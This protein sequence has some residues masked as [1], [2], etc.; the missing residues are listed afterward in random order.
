MSL[1]RFVYPAACLALLA[2]I[3][4]FAFQ[5]SVATA[6][7]MT[8][9][10][11]TWL[12]TLGPEQQKSALF[13]Y[14]APERLGWHFIP[15]ET[16]KG[17]ALRDMNADQKEAATRLL[18]S[19]LSNVGYRKARQVMSLEAL[20]RIL[21]DESGGQGPERD[22]AKYYFTI[23][24]KP[25]ADSRWG[26][27]IEGHH[28]SLNFVV[29]GDEVVSSSPTFFAANPTIVNRYFKAESSLSNLNRG[30]RVLNNEEL[31]AF[32]LVN[33]LTQDQLDQ[34]VFADKAPGEIRAA[35]EPQPPT[36]EAVGIPYSQLDKSQQ[37]RL[38]A[39][40]RTYAGNLP[41][42]I[43]AGH[44]KEIQQQGWKNVKF[45]WAGALRPGIG[46]YYRI[47]GPTFLIEFVNTQP[48]AE[49]NPASHIHCVWRDPR[50]DF[51]LSATE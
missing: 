31:I 39:L 43:S 35:G 47:Q 23:F 6:P 2:G 51:A 18:A 26:L 4:G 24:G 1:R 46:H 15:K 49:G 7:S 33:S 37:S 44:M 41:R 42:D 34:A 20:L 22:P 11:S 14:A 45:A 27:S 36:D 32:E 40:V 17:V 19:C 12:E 50:G 10:A 5:P 28:L 29:E 21:Q 9:A 16:R 38:M 13:D 25:T 3:A 30:D 48:D 8:A